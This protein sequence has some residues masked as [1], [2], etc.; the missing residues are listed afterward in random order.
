MSYLP[1]G[2]HACC[3][4]SFLDE[5]ESPTVREAAGTV[6]CNLLKLMKNHR[7]KVPP[8]CAK[9]VYILHVNK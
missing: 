5:H 6:F 1:G 3:L 4:S 8:S 9:N 7:S 2:F